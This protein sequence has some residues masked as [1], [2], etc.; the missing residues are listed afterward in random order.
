MLPGPPRLW[1]GS[2]FKWLDITISDEDVGSWPFS[3]G[4]WVK[5]A[6]FLSSLSCPS[7]VSDL[8]PGGVSYVELLILYERWAG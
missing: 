7:E 4:A 6:A 3:T 8:G 1:V 2:W 5:L